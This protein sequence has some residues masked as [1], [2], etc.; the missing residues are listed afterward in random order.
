MCMKGNGWRRMADEDE[1]EK[2]V[3]ESMAREINILCNSVKVFT[4]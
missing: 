2:E 3:D 1:Y 4:V